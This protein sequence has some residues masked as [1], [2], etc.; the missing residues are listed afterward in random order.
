MTKYDTFPGRGLRILEGNI[1]YWLVPDDT[2]T[3]KLSAKDLATGL[4]VHA[5]GTVV[6]RYPTGEMQGAQALLT[7]GWSKHE[8]LQ[9][10]KDEWAKAVALPIMTPLEFGVSR[11]MLELTYDQ[12]AQM[13]EVDLRTVK[14]WD[15]GQFTVSLDAT[16]TIRLMVRAIRQAIEQACHHPED[17]PIYPNKETY[18]VCDGSEMMWQKYHF[19][20]S[21]DGYREFLAKVHTFINL[22]S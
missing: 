13:L 19:A 1:E 21:W 9:G 3:M 2:G 20:M 15:E 5:P 22:F 6:H 4:V 7:L 10:Y 8:A 14:A 12:F 16:R 11:H 18:E 17:I